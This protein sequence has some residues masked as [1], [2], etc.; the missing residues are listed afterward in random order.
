MI[1]K[2]IGRTLPLL[3][4]RGLLVFPNTVLHFDVGR[5]KSIG[6]LEEAMVMDQK[7]LLV[8]QKDARTNFP[9]KDDIYKTGTVAKIKQ[10]LKMPQDTIRVLI[11]GLN[12]AVIK[13]Y[14]QTEPFFKVKVEE[15]YE[16]DE[17]DLLKK[18][19]L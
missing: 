12:R 4:L 2:D 14:I 11:E 8:A 15:V 3:P 9:D 10:L 16:G 1:K 5:D 18:K 19:L 13:E 7:I 17:K 6:A